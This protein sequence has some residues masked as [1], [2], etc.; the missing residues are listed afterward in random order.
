MFVRVVSGITVNTAGT[1]ITGY[2]S[3]FNSDTQIGIRNAADIQ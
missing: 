1:S 2:V 3:I